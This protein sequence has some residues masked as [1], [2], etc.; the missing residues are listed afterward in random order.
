MA[1][2]DNF[3]LSAQNGT[4][5]RVVTQWTFLMVV[6]VTS[7]QAMR[8]R[9][10]STHPTYWE[11]LWSMMLIFPILVVAAMLHSI[12]YLCQLRILM[13]ILLLEMVGT[14]TVMQTK[15][16]DTGAQNLISWRPIPMPGMPLHINVMLQVTRDFTTIVTEVEIASRLPMVESHMVQEIVTQSTLFNHSISKLTGVLMDHS[17]NTLRKVQKAKQWA[18]R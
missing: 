13:E 4:P 1:K 5:Q 14:T 6:E 11:V 17:L 9:E 16:V 18:P 12:S 2:I 10:S 15:L 3:I 7:L 8:T